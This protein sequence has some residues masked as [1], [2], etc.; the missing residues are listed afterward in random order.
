[1]RSPSLSLHIRKGDACTH[2]GDCRDLK[3]Y[4]P[5]IERLVSRYSLK[6][7][8][9]STPSVDV[10]QATAAYPHLHFAYTPVTRTAALLKVRRLSP[11]YFLSVRRA[12]ET[13]ACVTGR[14]WVR[15]GTLG[16]HAGG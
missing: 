8:F 7:I 3:Y 11:P 16:M 13:A 6:S 2:R 12:N 1:M 15:V 14:P 4:M 10:Q 9:L 5:H